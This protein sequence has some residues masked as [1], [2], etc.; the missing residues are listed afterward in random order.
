VIMPGAATVNVPLGV[1]ALLAANSY[2]FYG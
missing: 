2:G 1:E